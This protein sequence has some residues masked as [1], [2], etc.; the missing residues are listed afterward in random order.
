MNNDKDV[1][2]RLED[3]VKRHS[4][5][6]DADLIEVAEH[7]A[8]TGWDGFIYYDDTV[9]FYDANEDDIWE[10][11][12]REAEQAGNT[13]MELIASFGGAKQV[14]DNITFKNLLA[15]FALEE[16]GHFIERKEEFEEQTA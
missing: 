4:L 10:L 1:I 13:I 14:T 8:D 3:A 15:W 6:D 5:L 12:E 11:L 7:G 2:E 16:V 9:K